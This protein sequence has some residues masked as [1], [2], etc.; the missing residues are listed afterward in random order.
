MNNTDSATESYR[1]KE[2]IQFFQGPLGPRFSYCESLLKWLLY[3]WSKWPM[4]LWS[5]IFFN[6]PRY[7]SG[8]P[9][10][11]IWIFIQDKDFEGI[12]EDSE[13]LEPECSGMA[14]NRMFK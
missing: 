9:L 2:T 10:T 12:S 3:I 8:T 5:V 6:K 7:T 11:V 14:H 13:I 1:K 4:S